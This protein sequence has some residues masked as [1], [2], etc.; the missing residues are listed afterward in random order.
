MDVK[1]QGTLAYDVAS[2]LKLEL[3]NFLESIFRKNATWK[4]QGLRPVAW[5]LKLVLTKVLCVWQL[6]IV[7][8][9]CIKW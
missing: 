2:G 9:H 8:K 3:L 4:C 6:V 7:Y 1:L 5:R